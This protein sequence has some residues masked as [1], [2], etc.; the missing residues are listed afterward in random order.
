MILKYRSL[1]MY[2]P[3]LKIQ[4]SYDRIF[5]HIFQICPFPHVIVLTCEAFSEIHLLPI[6]DINDNFFP[7]HIFAK[8]EKVRKITI[9]HTMFSN[10]KM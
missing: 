10:L 3:I 4:T 2:F 8:I 5:I 7:N 9:V 1:Y 6:I